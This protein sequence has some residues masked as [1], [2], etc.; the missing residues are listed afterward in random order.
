[1]KHILH[2]QSFD[3]GYIGEIFALTNKIRELRKTFEGLEHLSNVLKHR[4]LYSFFYQESTRTRLSFE[5]AGETLGM[6]IRSTTDA[7]KLS[8][9]AKGETLEHSIRILCEY[10]AAAIVLRHRDEGAADRAAAVVEKYGYT[11]SIINGGDGVGQHPSQTVLDV[12]TVEEHAKLPEHPNF[13]LLGDLEHSRTIHSFAYYIPRHYPRVKITLVSP[14]EIR[15]K[16]GILEHFKEKGVEFEEVNDLNSVIGDADVIY[17]TRL[18]KEYHKDASLE[19]AMKN[20]FT[21]TTD[22]MAR[23][24]KS[25]A[26]LHPLPIVD[27]IHREVDDDPRALYFKQAGYGLPVRMA[28]LCHLFGVKL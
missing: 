3:R 1:M 24:K 4:T 17:C 20:G 21:I 12:F 23:A 18:Q 13:L 7:A 2:T 27:E 8:S 15:I 14:P 6:K 9:V 19:G 28:M 16:E 25:V 26:L 5:E 11:T 10:G 22:V